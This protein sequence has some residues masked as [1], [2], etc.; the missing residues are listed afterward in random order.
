MIIVL[1]N[2]R[3]ARF[4]FHANIKQ[5]VEIPKNANSHIFSTFPAKPIAKINNAGY[6]TPM[7]ANLMGIARETIAKK[8]TGLVLK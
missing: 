2:I 1:T 8:D 7:T 6:I 4:L 5:T 3:R